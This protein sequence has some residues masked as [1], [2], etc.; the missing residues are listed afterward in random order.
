MGLML[1]GKPGRAYFKPFGN[2]RQ[3]NFGKIKLPLLFQFFLRLVKN[4]ST[5]LFWMAPLGNTAWKCRHIFVCLVGPKNPK[6]QTNYF[7]VNISLQ[8]SFLMSFRQKKYCDALFG[9]SF[10]MIYF[11]C[12]VLAKKINWTFSPRRNKDRP[13]K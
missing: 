7:D 4:L 6:K 13:D 1:K 8:Y 3:F 9:I 12:F 5:F 10:L 11:R 2:Y